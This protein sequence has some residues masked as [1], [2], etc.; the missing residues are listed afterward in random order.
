MFK[1]PITS[2]PSIQDYA[3]YASLYSTVRDFERESRHHIDSLGQRKVW[4]INSTQ[5]GGGVAEMLPT[6][7]RIFTELGLSIEWKVIESNEQAFFQLTKRIHN[8]IH[9]KG[10]PGFTE[11]ERTLF[12]RVNKEN[13]D[14]FIDEIKDGDIVVVHDPQPMPLVKYIRKK[15]KISAV[16]RCHIGLDRSNR[17]TEAVWDF[18]STYVD[19]YDHFVFTAPEYLPPQ[20]R[21]N[22]SIVTPA[23][24][25]LSHKN[26]DLHIHKLTGILRNA[27]VIPNGHPEITP[28][29]KKTVSRIMPDGSY[30]SPLE[31]SDVGLIYRPVVT[32]IS[33]WD[34]LKGFQEV[35]EGF[36]HMKKN[37]ENLAGNESVKR[38]RLGAV[39][40]ILAGPDPEF[41][42]DDPEGQEVLHEI[43]S[44]YKKLDKK[45]ADD[46]AILLLPMESAKENALIVNA[47]QRCSSVVVQNS[48]EEGFGLTITEAMWK[49]KAV[50]AS[51]ATGL[52]KQIRHDIDGV[53]NDDP[54]NIEGFAI[55]LSKL[56]NKPK[57]REVLAYTAQRRV[58]DNFL[59]FTQL[60]NWLKVFSALPIHR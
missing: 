31:P 36:V 23:I 44:L 38:K 57:E 24:D 1:V 53:L 5:Q 42:K 17:Q 34:R 20:I 35:M 4:M 58:I 45:I 60:I 27:D 2:G 19:D 48:I 25:P 14:Q 37:I 40:L 52:K 28:K 54:Q 26:R 8:L 47:L 55:H 43:T 50:L 3:A 22:I 6:V 11:E 16:W 10:E 18:L 7:I 9:G 41:V 21:M 59:V 32:Q 30:R 51:N 56:L 49:I 33:R 12:E 13:A 46:I 39:R 29:F 15:K